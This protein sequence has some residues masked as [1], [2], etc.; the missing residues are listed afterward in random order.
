MSELRSFA[1]IHMTELTQATTLEIDYNGLINQN[2]ISSKQ[3]NSANSKSND[4]RSSSSFHRVLERAEDID[5]STMT[6]SKMRKTQ[7]LNCNS[8]SESF[9]S[10]RSITRSTSFSG[11]RTKTSDQ[12]DHRVESNRKP[13]IPKK[14]FSRKWAWLN[15]EENAVSKTQTTTKST[16]SSGETHEF[17]S[18]STRLRSLSLSTV[19]STETEKV[20]RFPNRRQSNRIKEMARRF[21]A[22]N[23]V[24]GS[25]ADDLRVKSFVPPRRIVVPRT[26]PEYSH[27]S[28][29]SFNSESSS[30]DVTN[31]EPSVVGFLE[32][33]A[34]VI[35]TGMKSGICQQPSI[36]SERVGNASLPIL[37]S[38]KLGDKNVSSYSFLEG[39]NLKAK[40]EKVIAVAIRNNN[41]PEDKTEVNNKGMQSCRFEEISNSLSKDSTKEISFLL[42]RDG[43]NS[44]HDD[45]K[46]IKMSSKSLVNDQSLNYS[47]SDTAH[48]TMIVE[49]VTDDRSCL[50][51]EANKQVVE[52]NERIRPLPHGLSSLGSSPEIDVMNTAPSNILEQES[53]V[54]VTDF[55]PE[56]CQRSSTVLEGEKKSSFPTTAPEQQNNVEKYQEVII[57]GSERNSEQLPHNFS[58]EVNLKNVIADESEEIIFEKKTF[59]NQR[60]YTFVVDEDATSYQITSLSAI[61]GEETSDPESEDDQDDTFTEVVASVES[62]FGSKLEISPISRISVDNDAKTTELKNSDFDIAR[63]QSDTGKHGKSSDLVLDKSGPKSI[64]NHADDI[65]HSAK[66]DTACPVSVDEEKFS[67][68]NQIL[69]GSHENEGSQSHLSYSS[70]ANANGTEKD[71]S[72]STDDIVGVQD[73]QKRTANLYGSLKDSVTPLDENSGCDHSLTSLKKLNNSVTDTSDCVSIHPWC[74]SKD[75]VPENTE[76]DQKYGFIRSDPLELDNTDNNGFENYDSSEIE[77]R[78]GTCSPDHCLKISGSIS[79]SGGSSPEIEQCLKSG[80]SPENSVENRPPTPSPPSSRSSTNNGGHQHSPTIQEHGPTFQEHSPTFREHSPTF[81]EHSPTFQEHSPTFREHS[82]AFQEH[83]PTFQE[84]SPTF[85]EHSSTFQEHSPTFQ[86]HSPTFREHSPTFQERSPTFQEHSPTVQEHRPTLLRDSSTLP[87]EKI[88]PG[89]NEIFSNRVEENRDEEDSVSCQEG[90]S[91]V[92][93]LQS[94]AKRFCEVETDRS[95]ITQTSLSSVLGTDEE[96]QEEIEEI[97]ESHILSYCKDTNYEVVEETITKQGVEEQV[98]LRNLDPDVNDLVPADTSSVEYDSQDRGK[99]RELQNDPKHEEPVDDENIVVSSYFNESISSGTTVDLNNSTFVKRREISSQ[100]FSDKLSLQQTTGSEETRGL[101]SETHVEISKDL[102]VFSQNQINSNNPLSTRIS[103]LSS[104]SE[105]SET[106]TECSDMSTEQDDIVTEKTTETAHQAPYWTSHQSTEYHDMSVLT[107]DNRV[108]LSGGELHAVKVKIDLGSKDSMQK[109]KDLQKRRT[110]GK[111]ED[112]ADTMKIQVEDLDDIS[113]ATFLTAEDIKKIASTEKLSHQNL[114]ITPDTRLVDSYDFLGLSPQLHTRRSLSPRITDHLEGLGF[115]HDHTIDY[116]YVSSPVDIEELRKFTPGVRIGC[117]SSPEETVELG[118]SL[119]SSTRV[120]F[121][122]FVHSS[123]RS[124]DISS[125]CVTK[126][127]AANRMVTKFERKKSYQPLEQIKINFDRSTEVK[128]SL[129][130]SRN[131]T[132]STVDFNKKLIEHEPEPKR[133]KS[134]RKNSLKGIFRK[135]KSIK[136]N[137]VDLEPDVM[138]PE[139]EISG[140]ILIS[141]SSEARAKT[142]A[143]AGSYSFSTQKVTLEELS[144]SE[145]DNSVSCPVPESP[146]RSTQLGNGVQIINRVDGFFVPNPDTG[147]IDMLNPTPNLDDKPDNPSGSVEK[148][149]GVHQRLVFKKSDPLA[150]DPF[151]YQ[152][153]HSFLKKGAEVE[154]NTRTGIDKLAKVIKWK[155]M[156]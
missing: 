18:I 138:E 56:I 111:C 51:I 22:G 68:F 73:I 27:F 82:P 8:E 144:I 16:F 110:T 108:S 132:F 90:D 88:V 135:M 57:A 105:I 126:V 64:Q 66:L 12:L 109:L 77:S 54:I 38:S 87:I 31:L 150:P 94:V 1:H 84:H 28:S 117:S 153:K 85:Q 129:S 96:S 72:K 107:G 7:S 40:T 123:H 148:S 113:D 63:S 141:S 146:R 24:D 131:V 95:S 21:E 65:S 121:G 93:I 143:N 50:E 98:K 25:D 15:D 60:L 142:S 46:T 89:E 26:N 42:L 78:T 156:K 53:S 39:H 79:I 151:S 41:D 29:D 70:L 55:N 80:R 43:A 23:S 13:D 86:E 47:H 149:S 19:A 36:K 32:Q 20:E 106:T 92:D 11:A 17:S 154:Q 115:H 61:S 30:A 120:E 118:S 114:I 33:E 152:T 9:T 112:E 67:T 116:D 75:M 137:S 37:R 59:P 6:N 140:P 48:I 124:V 69:I 134:W 83:S 44:V 99:S 81:Q 35:R 130:S 3:L 62:G 14:P 122:R 58:P 101:K 102:T 4:S 2:G 119:N 71:H 139:M 155:R 145:L 74:C 127:V 76:I 97:E 10:R 104:C 52:E 125:R 91:T 49:G 100:L 5:I 128:P 103:A 45:P 34:S 136:N 133:S 147:Q